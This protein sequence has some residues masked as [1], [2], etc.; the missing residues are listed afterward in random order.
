MVSHKMGLENKVISKDIIK[1]EKMALKETNVPEKRRD[2][3]TKC[4]EEQGYQ[5]IGWN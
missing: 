5:V 2:L 4:L 1:C 3:Q